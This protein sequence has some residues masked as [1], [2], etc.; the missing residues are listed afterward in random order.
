M[1]RPSKIKG[2]TVSKSKDGKT[3]LKEIPVARNVSERIRQRKSTKQRVVRKT[4]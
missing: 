2:Y 3:V 1:T 4:P